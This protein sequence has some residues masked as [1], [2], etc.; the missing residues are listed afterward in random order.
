MSS[1]KTGSLSVYAI[2][3][4][5]FTDFILPDAM[6][7]IAPV[8][9]SEIPTYFLTDVFFS[10]YPCIAVTLIQQQAKVFLHRSH[11]FTNPAT[12]NSIHSTFTAI[13]FCHINHCKIIH[14]T[15][16]LDNEKDQ[17]HPIAS[18]SRNRGFSSKISHKIQMCVQIFNILLIFSKESF[19]SIFHLHMVDIFRCVP[20]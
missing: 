19:K 20:Q 17:Y 4:Q 13:D 3:L 11:D 5:I 2:L 8:A 18:T 10:L 6:E 16:F 1:G 12:S 14:C 9:I 7:L 15:K